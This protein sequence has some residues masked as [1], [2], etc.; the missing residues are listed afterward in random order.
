M[1]LPTYPTRLAQQMAGLP[2]GSVKAL[3]AAL[4][5]T[6]SAYQQWRNGS[7]IPTTTTAIAVVRWLR[8]EHGVDTSV[9]ALWG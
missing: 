4:G 5:V 8:S 6:P 2:R 7:H 3:C 1:R 9:E